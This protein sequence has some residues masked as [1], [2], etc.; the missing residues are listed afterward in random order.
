MED[1]EDERDIPDQRGAWSGGCAGRHPPIPEEHD[2][3]A[4][5]A[6]PNDYW[7]YYSPDEFSDEDHH[8]IQ[9]VQWGVDPQDKW[10]GAARES[11]KSIKIPTIQCTQ[12][13]RKLMNI[14]CFAYVDKKWQFVE[15][16]PINSQEAIH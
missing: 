12:C 9:G 15:K 10:E 1:A 3:R 4:D 7:T 6:D 5:G 11:K 2:W 16:L 13:P 14:S 8:R